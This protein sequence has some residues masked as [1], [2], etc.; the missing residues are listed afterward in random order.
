MD[1]GF[2]ARSGSLRR[3]TAPIGAGFCVGPGALESAGY[4]SLRRSV[5]RNGTSLAG[6]DPRVRR[7]RFVRALQMAIHSRAAVPSRGLHRLFLVGP[8]RNFACRFLL[9]RLARPDANLWVLSH[10][11]RENRNIRCTHPPPRFRDVRYLV[12]DSGSAFAIP[13]E[14]YARHVLY[15]WRAVYPGVNN[16]FRPTADSFG[17]HRGVGPFYPA[18]RTDVARRAPAQSR[19]IGSACYEHRILV[20]L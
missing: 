19:E 3:N 1:F 8:E 5:W 16:S 13:A 11:R 7:S 9:G 20:V 18:L 15:V 10:I 6:N 17:G 4:L 12:C 2:L 14:R